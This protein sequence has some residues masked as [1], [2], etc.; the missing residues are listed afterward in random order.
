MTGDQALRIFSAAQVEQVA[1]C[2][3]FLQ[4]CTRL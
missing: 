2:V 3:A 1:E 4:C